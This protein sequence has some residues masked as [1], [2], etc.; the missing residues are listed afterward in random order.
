MLKS[1]GKIGGRMQ[2]G[3]KNQ[4]GRSFEEKNGYD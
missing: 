4:G 3:I 1:R 2:N